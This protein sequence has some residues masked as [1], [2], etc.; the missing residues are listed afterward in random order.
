MPILYILLMHIYCALSMFHKL[1]SWFCNLLEITSG[2]ISPI[3]ENWL[4]LV[5]NEL[6]NTM[7]QQ[8]TNLDIYHYKERNLQYLKH[9]VTNFPFYRTLY[10][11]TICVLL[12]FSWYLLIDLKWVYT[13]L[14]CNILNIWQVPTNKLLILSAPQSEPTYVLTIIM[15]NH[16]IYVSSVTSLHDQ[17]I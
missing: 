14:I 8:K 3:E 5:T 1:S 11:M 12:V 17:F 9:I 15:F 10:G 7:F 2:S 13:K 6:H 4:L 16:M